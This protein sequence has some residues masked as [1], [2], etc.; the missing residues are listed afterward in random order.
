MFFYDEMITIIIIYCH[1][2]VF[3]FFDELGSLVDYE[4]LPRVISYERIKSQTNDVDGH[5]HYLSLS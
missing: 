1:F 2:V 4:M 5:D 3:H